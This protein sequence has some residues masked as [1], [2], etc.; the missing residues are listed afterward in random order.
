MPPRAF[1]GRRS[2][3]AGGS[4]LFTLPYVF[5]P[6]RHAAIAMPRRSAIYAA[7]VLRSSHHE[8]STA[9]ASHA[10]RHVVRRENE[11]GIEYVTPYVAPASFHRG[12]RR[13]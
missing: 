10:R 13:P 3:F 12:T 9:S 2:E 4:A 7:D 8:T 6:P 1:A 5:T 11:F